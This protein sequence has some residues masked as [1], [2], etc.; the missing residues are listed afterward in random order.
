MTLPACFHPG[1]YEKTA[2]HTR[3]IVRMIIKMTV[4]SR[5][6]SLGII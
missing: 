1:I 5:I 3:L 2:I 6:L 4:V